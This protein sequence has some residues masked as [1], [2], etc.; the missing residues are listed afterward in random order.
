M[1]RRYVRLVASVLGA[2]LVAVPSLVFGAEARIELGVSP[3]RVIIE[4][5]A[6]GAPITQTLTVRVQATVAAEIKV[7]ISDV[8]AGPD[9]TLVSA[10]LGSTPY[11][12]GTSTVVEPALILV[13]PSPDLQTFDVKITVKAAASDPPHLGTLAVSLFPRGA[14]SGVEGVV[15]QGL[16]MNATVLSG[17]PE[18][19]E[20]AIA[21]AQ[22]TLEGSALT[23]V[24]TTPWTV[25]D[26]LI[27]DLIP[28]LVDHGPVMATVRYLNTG[29]V[30]LD[31]TTSFRF[32][33]VGPLAW[34]PGSTD[35]GSP[36]YTI[37]AAP[38]YAL[39]GQVMSTDADSLLRAKDAAPVDMLPFIGFVRITTTTSG[40]LG[41]LAAAP[42]IQSTV[43]FIFP[44]K[45]LLA[46]VLLLVLLGVLRTLIGR[47]W[48]RARG[49]GKGSL[50]TTEPAAGLATEPSTP[51]TA[52]GDSI[53]GP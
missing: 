33:S 31:A 25:F 49:R 4:A 6:D 2:A 52:V 27:P 44:W 28:G 45:E 9:G 41:A 22:A 8:V 46:L 16:G 39:P 18:G 47:G 38:G 50:A 24:R 53:T 30:I 36:F 23:V 17:P 37:T 29:N 43:I 20:A 14:S 1:H 21:N 12:L 3:R 40:T 35:E 34:L 13:D 7:A 10:P 26:Q 5:R 42:V 15:T 19:G 32:A 11:S 51:D 48:R